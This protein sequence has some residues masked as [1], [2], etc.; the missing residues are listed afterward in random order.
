MLSIIEDIGN[1]FWMFALFCNV[2]LFV[3]CLVLCVI[4]LLPVSFGGEFMCSEFALGASAVVVRTSS[5]P[6]C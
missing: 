3:G 5:L 4:L 1:I 2:C 6:K